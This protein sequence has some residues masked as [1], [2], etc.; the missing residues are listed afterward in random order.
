MKFARL[1]HQQHNTVQ[2]CDFFCTSAPAMM[3]RPLNQLTLDVLLRR[4]REV[5]RSKSET[6]DK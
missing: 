3:A 4:A 2:A 6:K 1:S 5:R